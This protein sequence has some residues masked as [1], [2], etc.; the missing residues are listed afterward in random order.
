M[1]KPLLV[2]E[3][4]HGAGAIAWGRRAGLPAAIALV[5]F[6]AGATCL[7]AVMLQLQSNSGELAVARAE[8]TRIDAERSRKIPVQKNELNARQRHALDAVARELNTPW[9]QLLDAMEA[10]L[11]EDV[12]LVSI[13]P[14]GAS[15]KVRIQAESRALDSLLA[16]ASTLRNVPMFASVVLVKH[17]TNEQDPNRPVRLVLEAEFA[18][19]GLAE[20]AQR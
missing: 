11:P 5:A 4:R 13:E 12:A 15:G 14:N 20:G 17:E 10:S 18:Q 1:N 16:Y 8:A 19:R 2:F 3:H 6:A 7:G 9:S